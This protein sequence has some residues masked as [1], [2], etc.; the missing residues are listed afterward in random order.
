MVMRNPLRVAVARDAYAKSTR[1]RD[2][3]FATRNVQNV[4]N[5]VSD[6]GRTRD[7]QDHN[8]AL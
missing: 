4:T 7:L 2:Q 6:G 3:T 1:R 5:G 8:L